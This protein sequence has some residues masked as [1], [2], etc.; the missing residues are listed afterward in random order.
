MIFFTKF[1]MSF[2]EEKEMS[3]EIT[4]RSF[5][6][7]IGVVGGAAAMSSMLSGC[8]KSNTGVNIPEKWDREIDVLVVGFGIAGA[9]AALNAK[10]AGAN[11][12]ARGD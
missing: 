12:L 3:K 8:S 11:A 6:K 1:I 9:S 10:K 7:E 2:F 5:L 4:R